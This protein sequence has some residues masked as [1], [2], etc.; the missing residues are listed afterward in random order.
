MALLLA[1]REEAKS[2][3]A[4]A[5]ARHEQMMADWKAWREEMRASRKETAAEIEP[6]TE[7]RTTACQEMKAR[8]EE[9]KPTSPDRKPEA[10][11]RREVPEV[12][13]EVMPVGEPKKKRRM[14]R[15]LATE[16]SRQKPKNSTRENC[17]PQKKLAVARGGTTRRAKVARK[18]PMDRKM[19]RRATVTRRK[20]GIVKS[21]ITQEKCHPR[22]ELV[23]SRTR[24][25]HRAKVARRKEN[26]VGRDRTRDKVMLGTSKGGTL[27][28][29]NGRNR[30]V[31]R[32]TKIEPYGKM[33]GH[34]TAKRIIGSPVPSQNVK[35]WI[36][37]RGRPHPKRKKG[38]GPHGRNR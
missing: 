29:D 1:M 5:D 9:R 8:Q 35:N 16:R 30:N 32:G 34:E 19:S 33:T 25:T 11:E 38:N 31:T 3:Q 27:G 13:A 24:T 20:R 4:K 6:E 28:R 2:N 37:W 17:K 22:R 10:A 14:D 12:D 23:A 21:Y 36:L 15:K 18:A 7:I 26:S